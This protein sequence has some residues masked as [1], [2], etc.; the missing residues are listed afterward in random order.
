MKKISIAILAIIAIVAIIVACK[1]TPNVNLEYVDVERD[2][3]TVG[4]TTAT[5]QCDYEYI[6]TLK[7]AYLYYG[8]GEDATDMTSAEMRVVQNTLYVDLSGLK[9]NTTYSYYYEFYNGF[10]SMRTEAKTFKTENSPGGG[11]GGGYIH[12]GAL[13]GLFSVS[14]D[15]KISFS[16]GNLQYQASTNTWRFAENQWNQVGGQYVGGFECGN[17]YENGEKC[18]NNL[19]SST[20]SGWFDLFCWATSGWDCGNVYYHPYDVDGEGEEYGPGYNNLT[21]EY[22]NSDWGVYNSIANGGNQPGLWRTLTE[23]EW[24]YIAEH[25]PQATEKY[26]LAQV[27]GVHGCI[28]LP[29]DWNCPTGLSFVPRSFDWTTNV[30]SEQEWIQMETN[31]AVF[32]PASGAG[33]GFALLNYDSCEYHTTNSGGSNWAS[34][35]FMISNNGFVGD[36]GYSRVLSASVRLVQDG[37]PNTPIFEPSVITSEVSSITSNSAVCGGEV[38][39]DGGAEVTERGICWSMNS[40][41]TLNDSHIATGAGTGA[42]TAVMNGLEASTTYHIC[43]YATNSSGTAYGLDKIFTTLSDGGGGPT[44]EGYFTIESLENNN[45]ITL[46]IPRAIDSQCLTSVSYSTDG[47]IWTTIN[48]DATDQTISVTL[49]Q[50][51]TVRFKGLG[52]KYAK[53]WELEKHSYFNTSG[54]ITVSGNI[55]SLLYGDDFANTTVFPSGSSNTFEGLFQD[56]DKLISAGNLFLPATSLVYECYREMFHGCSS[57]T[58]APTLP[59]NSLAY[60]CYNCMFMYCSSLMDAPTLSATILAGSCYHGMFWECTSLTEAPALPATILA[61][62][63]YDSMFIGCSALTEAPALPAT[64]LPRV[65]YYDM[66]RDCTSLKRAPAL[67]AIVLADWCYTG[68]F[69][70]CTSLTEAPALPATTLTLNCYS[71]MFTGCTSLVEAPALPATILAEGCYWCM[72]SNCTSLTRTPALLATVLEDRSYA[73]MFQWCTSLVEVTCLA[74]NILAAD[75][76]S[77]WLAGVPSGGTFYKNAAMNDWPLN[78]DSGI[79]NG[80]NVIDY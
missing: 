6:A 27:N 28:L 16:Q 29:D 13:P 72:F 52:L 78:S 42:F 36:T 20:Y 35:H 45:T 68:M 30:Y 39:N 1:K 71:G 38:T 22:A 12:E 24:Y 63:C 37:A 17:V 67:P 61:E 57:L 76:T 26:S 58:V 14:P 5:V 34:T 2:L 79:P 77:S 11:G 50:G 51:E 73:G 31:G 33:N 59:A 80:W 41:P 43:A 56:A 64:V 8:E 18:T 62:G 44:Q 19:I 74:T 54:N 4:T 53:N 48:I 70:G 46:N 23:S 55:M 25:R 21:G 66:F 65:C 9:E 75:C 3:I 32:L 69:T 40:N 47:M 10:N 60:G 49:N 7:K 15:K